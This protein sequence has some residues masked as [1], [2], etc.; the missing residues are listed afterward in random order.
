MSS[1]SFSVLKAVVLAVVADSRSGIEG[2]PDMET[3]VYSELIP[4]YWNVKE[5]LPDLEP[6][7]K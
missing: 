6:H 2:R 1:S 5:E 4:D 3:Y 7:G